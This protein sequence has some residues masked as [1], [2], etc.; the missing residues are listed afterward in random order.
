MIHAGILA[1][2]LLQHIT[3]ASQFGLPQKRETPR[4][5]NFEESTWT[6]TG[7][8]QSVQVEVQVQVQENQGMLEYFSSSKVSQICRSSS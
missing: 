5:R 4:T 8:S 3:Q 7:F 6:W 2:L 1:K